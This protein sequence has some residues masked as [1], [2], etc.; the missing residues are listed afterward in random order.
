[1][2]KIN[3][4]SAPKT[5]VPKKSDCC[6]GDHKKDQKAQAS[7]KEHVKTSDAAHSGD[8]SHT[9]SGSGCCGGSKAHK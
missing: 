9:R 8:D 4:T 3:E 7:G 5:D 6:G 2:S 1:M